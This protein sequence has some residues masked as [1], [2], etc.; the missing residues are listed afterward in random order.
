MEQALHLRQRLASLLDAL[1]LQRN[2]TKGFWEPCP[3]GRHLGVDIDSTS[4]MFYPPADKL[5]RL[6]RRANRLIG[7]ATQTARWLP[8]RELQSQAWQAQYLFLVIPAARFFL[9]KLHSVGAS[10]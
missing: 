3:F 10:G 2:P 9:L 6:T 5:K 4:G 1:G 7:R 8:V